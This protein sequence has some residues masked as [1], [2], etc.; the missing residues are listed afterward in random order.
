MICNWYMYW[1]RPA[2]TQNFP[3]KIS[4]IYYFTWWS[5]IKLHFIHIYIYIPFQK[6]LFQLATANSGTFIDIYLPYQSTRGED[7]FHEK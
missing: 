1:F 5:Q 6:D 7:F 4:N 3:P 2:A